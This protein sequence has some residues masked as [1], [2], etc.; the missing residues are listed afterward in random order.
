[1]CINYKNER[2]IRN[3]VLTRK[4]SNSFFIF[5]FYFELWGRVSIPLVI[6]NLRTFYFYYCLILFVWFYFISVNAFISSNLCSIFL[7]ISFCFVIRLYFFIFH[8]ILIYN[9]FFIQGVINTELVPSRANKM[10]SPFFPA[11]L[12]VACSG[13]VGQNSCYKVSNMKENLIEKKKWMKREYK[14][15]WMSNNWINISWINPHLVYFLQ[16]K[17]N[18][19]WINL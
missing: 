11:P 17:P 19:I 16:I 6:F 4:N 7:S 10:T 2:H 18:L 3:I 15:K 9:L 12:K 14:R 1:M 5:C 13:S 8:C